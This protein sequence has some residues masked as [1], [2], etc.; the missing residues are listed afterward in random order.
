MA[1]TVRDVDAYLASLGLSERITA[2]Q[3]DTYAHSLSHQYGG[4]TTVRSPFKRLHPRLTIPRREL[5]SYLAAR[6]NR[7]LPKGP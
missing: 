6:A 3:A 2:L 5:A 7:A 1:V 4:L